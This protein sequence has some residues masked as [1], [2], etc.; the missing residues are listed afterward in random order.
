MQQHSTTQHNNTCSWYQDQ[1]GQQAWGSP[2]RQ[3]MIPPA[4]MTSVVS[5]LPLKWVSRCFFLLLFFVVVLCV[6]CVDSLVPSSLLSLFSNAMYAAG[7]VS[8]MYEAMNKQATARDIAHF[9]VM[10]SSFPDGLP[11]IQNAAGLKFHPQVFFFLFCVI[12]CCCVLLCVVLCCTVCC[13][14]LCCAVALWRCVIVSLCPC[15][16]CVGYEAEQSIEQNI[17]KK[18]RIRECGCKKSAVIFNWRSSSSFLS[19]P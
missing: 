16:V 3:A 8:L 6:C 14:V 19:L 12:V 4:I 10:S 2:S 9:L 1:E 18:D 13:A 11:S 5:L 17:D 15:V 7:V